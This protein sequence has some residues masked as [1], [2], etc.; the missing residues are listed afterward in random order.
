MRNMPSYQ[1]KE[2]LL[3]VA[4][5]LSERKE[6]LAQLLAIEAGKPV[7]DGRVEVDRAVRLSVR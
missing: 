7:K 4:S 6:E 3:Q 1:R 5:G 2:I